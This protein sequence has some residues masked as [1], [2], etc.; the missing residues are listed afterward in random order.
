M[1]VSKLTVQKIE[2]ATGL[3]LTDYE[4]EDFAPYDG[5]LCYDG[6]R[7]HVIEIKSRK[8]K[9]TLEFLKSKGTI[10]IDNAKIRK[11]ELISY[12]NNIRST[13][14][15][16]TSDGYIIT[17]KLT[18]EKGEYQVD[19]SDVRTEMQPIHENSHKKQ[20]EKL[21]HLNINESI[22]YEFERLEKE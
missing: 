9:Y 12:L 17:F 5:F 21:T 16:E 19:V 20:P 8:G 10:I 13:L 2:A 22:I 18:N 11:L 4:H 14:F 1:K 15:F 7:R 6:E 3:K